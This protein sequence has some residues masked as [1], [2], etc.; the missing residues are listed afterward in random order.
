MLSVVVENCNLAT[1]LYGNLVYVDD[2]NSHYP[3][4]DNAVIKEV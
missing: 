4:G 3:C 2:V 1:A